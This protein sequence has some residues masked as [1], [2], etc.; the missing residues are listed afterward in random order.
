MNPKESAAVPDVK[1]EE[2]K[3]SNQRTDCFDYKWASVADGLG[4]VIVDTSEEVAQ[5]FKDAHN[6]SIQRV[7]EKTKAFKD[8][9]HRR[10]DTAG[11]PKEFPDG[12][13]TKEG[14]RIGDRLDWVLEK[15]D[16]PSDNVK[17]Q[18]DQKCPYRYCG[19]KSYKTFNRCDNCGREW[20]KKEAVADSVEA[21]K[22]E[23]GELGAELA[24]TV[25]TQKA[26]HDWLKPQCSRLLY[27]RCDTRSCLVRGKG[28]NGGTVDY[29]KAT[30]E[31]FEISVLLGGGS[32]ALLYA[33]KS[34]IRDLEHPRSD[35]GNVRRGS[36]D[37]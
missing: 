7:L 19:S 17:A 10:L 29:S 4:N 1:E 6:A 31:P 18:P 33:C 21:Q 28:L 22:E 27:G 24:A 2:W 12:E 8:F 14:C 13:H 36:E 20:E 25:P 30:C 5:E 34:V 32:D 11:V 9:V 26:L 37:F 23:S 3:L 16:T 15:K 35:R